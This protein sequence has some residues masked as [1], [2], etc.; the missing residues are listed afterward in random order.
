MSEWSDQMVSLLHELSVLKE[1]EKAG[2]AAPN[3][4]CCLAEHESRVTRIGEI[5]AEMHRVAANKK[6]S[7]A[8]GPEAV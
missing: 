6:A 3:D 8:V 4:P 7:T 1:L 2:E 5:P